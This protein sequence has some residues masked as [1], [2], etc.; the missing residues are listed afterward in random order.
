MISTDL[1]EKLT[2]IGRSEFD[3]TEMIELYNQAKKYRQSCGA[4]EMINIGTRFWKN[5]LSW[6]VYGTAA[7]KRN[8]DN[9]VVR[10][11]E[12]KKSRLIA[13]DMNIRLKNPIN[14]NI[15]GQDVLEDEMNF[16]ID[17][18]NITRGTDGVIDGKH[19]WGLGFCKVGWDKWHYE[20]GW[21]TGVPTVRSCDTRK[22]YVS[23][24]CRDAYL[25]DNTLYCEVFT[26]E[27]KALKR[28]LRSGEYDNAGN[29]VE[30]LNKLDN[31]YEF[32]N[33]ISK[34]SGYGEFIDVVVCQYQDP[35]IFEM[36][37]IKDYISDD[38]PAYEVFEE[39]L[40]NTV[41]QDKMDKV[42]DIDDNDALPEGIK[43]S[44]SYKRRIDSWYECVIIPGLNMLLHRTF[45]VGD[46]SEYVQYVGRNNP[47]S[48][49]KFS[50]AYDLAQI[51]EIHG[52]A[53]NM[54]LV[55]AIK[56]F[57][58]IP[59]ID[60]E[61][62][63][64]GQAFVDNWENWDQVL[65]VKDGYVE[66]TGKLPFG[67]I[68]PP[69]GGID[70]ERLEAQMESKL[71]DITRSTPALM[72]ESGGSH[73]SAKQTQVLSSNAMNSSRIDYLPYEMLQQQVCTRIKNMIAEYK[74]FP[75][76]YNWMGKKIITVNEKGGDIQLMDVA[77]HCMVIVR[78][79]DSDEAIQESKQDRILQMTAD[80]FLPYNY[81]IWNGGLDNP[82]EIIS[83]KEQQDQAFKFMQSVQELAKTDPTAF[84]MYFEMVQKAIAEGAVLEQNDRVPQ[85]PQQNKTSSPQRA[86]A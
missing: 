15:I 4:E 72:G 53:M 24:N 67:W 82:E 9:I 25:K 20:D 14:P 31:H 11:L 62:I 30:T 85:Q 10:N 16:S 36:R 74:N 51:Q 83:E 29:V 73:Q 34:Q 65:V 55:S 18:H 70:L 86:T 42:E 32:N 5:D 40:V 6:G 23:P 12:A 17:F 81:G 41:G 61:G 3:L 76:K 7:E 79:A 60:P 22:M 19:Y 52:I 63:E 37:T 46:E 33:L 64:N 2:E 56:L 35:H 44:K 28:M 57:K 26:Y 68:K 27:K 21:E 8:F 71:A 47:D 80:G 75:H 13:H 38:E 66:K 1:K 78:E 48:P 43:A 39:D 45:C 58:S 50:D 84:Q 54:R 77:P 69:Q 49:Y 59:W